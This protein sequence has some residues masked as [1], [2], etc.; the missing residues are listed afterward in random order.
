MIIYHYQLNLITLPYLALAINLWTP[1]ASMTIKTS[2]IGCGRKVDRKL[3]TGIKLFERQ[4]FCKTISISLI[5]YIVL[6]NVDK[7][8]L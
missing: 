5:L 8:K 6:D 7:I 2:E 3:L 1:F 4:S